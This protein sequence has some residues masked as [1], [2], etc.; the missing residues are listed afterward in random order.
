[1]SPAPFSPSC[2]QNV[3]EAS[4]R[5]TAVPA[6]P[7]NGK[8][9]ASHPPHCSYRLLLLQLTLLVSP[10]HRDAQRGTA[11]PE[12]GGLGKRPAEKG[13]RACSRETG[14]Q[15]PQVPGQAP[16]GPAGTRRCGHHPASDATRCGIFESW[17]DP[18]VEPA[19]R[20]STRI[21]SETL[22]AA[23]W[24]DAPRIFGWAS[25]SP[26]SPGTRGGIHACVRACVCVRARVCACVRAR[27]GVCACTERGRGS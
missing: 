13:D 17:R 11:F 21:F 15:G 23:A 27:A 25:R 10:Q 6:V 3:G 26:P 7:C 8:G 16:V 2:S 22:C 4:E 1:M 12:S 19:R 9:T 18:V 24:V 20:T 5:R 14:L